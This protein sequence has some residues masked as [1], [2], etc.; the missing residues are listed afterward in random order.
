MNRQ[1][2]ITLLSIWIIICSFNKKTN[3][4]IDYLIYGVYCGECTEHC[5]TMFRLDKKQL[6]I[7]TTDTF[8]KN[9]G[10]S[11]RVFFKAD[12]LNNEQ[13]QEAKVLKTAL[14]R[15]LLQSKDRDFGNPDNHDQ[16]GIYIQFK[17]DK[18]LK[19]FYIDTDL[20]KIPKELRDYAELVMKL[21]KANSQ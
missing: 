19:T 21:S 17:I 11:E 7:D 2:L 15:I 4:N 20:E 16:C 1:L 10:K 3:H 14:P 18:Q 6:F 12:T 8:F 9:I 13:F 5:S